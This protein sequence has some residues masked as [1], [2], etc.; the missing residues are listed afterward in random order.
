MQTPSTTMNREQEIRSNCSFYE[1][2]VSAVIRCTDEELISEI[3]TT[4]INDE[5]MAFFST[6]YRLKPYSF[7]TTES[8]DTIRVALDDGSKFREKILSITQRACALLGPS[9]SELAAR[10]IETEDTGK[11]DAT[12]AGLSLLGEDAAKEIYNEKT[13]LINIITANPWLVV[14]CV[15]RMHFTMSETFQGSVLKLPKKG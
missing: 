13:L 2:A 14:L 9:F 10:L 15:L 5:V 1:N 12:E 7:W 3:D 8:L 11:A 4:R 6:V